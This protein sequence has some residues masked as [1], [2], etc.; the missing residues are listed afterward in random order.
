MI[1]REYKCRRRGPLLPMERKLV[2]TNCTPPRPK[3]HPGV[4]PAVWT[5]FPRLAELGSF[6]R[7]RLELI[8]DCNDA[9][10]TRHKRIF[11]LSLLHGNFEEGFFWLC[12]RLS[13][14]LN[15]EV[16]APE[17]VWKQLTQ[18]CR[19]SPKGCGLHLQVTL[20]CEE[21]GRRAG[22]WL[23]CGEGGGGQE[24]LISTDWFT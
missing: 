16:T 20:G 1:R 6:L 12:Y 23:W 5:L 8:L 22:R 4:Y 10:T 11:T 7:L 21:G 9:E 15:A 18:Q 19:E 2:P 3:G 17:L 24:S 14:Y 13:F